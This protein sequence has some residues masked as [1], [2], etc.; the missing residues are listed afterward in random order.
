VTEPVVNG[1]AIEVDTTNP[2]RERIPFSRKLAWTLGLAALGLYVGA[3]GAGVV[4]AVQLEHID[5]VHKAGNLAILTSFGALFAMIST[6]LWGALSDRVRS[7]WGRRNPVAFVGAFLI[8]ISLTGMALSTTVVELG[9]ALCVVEV[10]IGSVLAPLSAVIP[11]R[12]PVPARGFVSA[13]LGLGVMAGIAIGSAVGASLAASS[14]VLAYA[15]LAVIILVAL[16][17]FV[18]LNPDESSKDAPRR[19]FSFGALM[20]SYWVNPRRYPDF[21]WVFFGRAFMFLG[22]AAVNTY[23]L[24]ILQ[25]YVGLTLNRALSEVPI[26]AVASFIG[27]LASILVSGRLSDRLGKRKPFVIASSI[28]CAIGVALPLVFPSVPGMIAYSFLTGVGYGCYLSI[29]NA[30]ITQVLPPTG[31]TAKDLGV[32]AIGGS[33][34][35]VIA[36]AVAGTIVTIT[37]QYQALFLIACAVSIV[38]AILI[39]PVK[40]VR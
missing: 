17:L 2:A 38:G 1:L 27:I 36:P 30:L 14:I 37:G 26:L 6:P 23:A 33:A 19:G 31:E 22:Y 10:C 3:T 4:A 18:L 16:L 20:R 12:I 35:T 21:A 5:P 25:D 8:V 29:D 39:L 32:A 9:I 40:S 24:Y 34:A 15:V 13:I 28:I 7:R 11:D